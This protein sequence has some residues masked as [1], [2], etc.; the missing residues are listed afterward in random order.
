VIGESVVESRFEALHGTMSGPFVG[1]DKEL[2]LLLDRWELARLGEGQ[3]VLLAGEPGIGKSRIVLALRERLRLEDRISLRYHASP[4][5]ANS[6]WWPIVQQLERAAGF[7]RDDTNAAKLA[8]LEALLAQA[9]GDVADVIPFFADLLSL[10]T[11]GGYALP[12]LVPQEKKARTCRALLAQLEGL[13]AQKPVLIV[14]EDAHWL[15]PTTIEL[16]ELIVQ[17]LERLPVL[18]V[19]TF[20]PE[21]KPPWTGHPHVTALTLNR[22]GRVA[23]EAIMER[24]SGSRRLPEGLPAEILARA[25]GVP[26]FVEELT[27]TILESGILGETADAYPLD[28]SLLRQAIPA[29]LQDSLMARLDRLAPVKEVAQIGAVI[30]R[31]FSRELLV[32]V[33]GMQEDQLGDAMDRLADAGLIFARGMPPEITYIFKHSLVQEAARESLL[34]SRRH[35]LN[36]KVAEVLESRFPSL[37]EAEPERLAHHL[38]EAGLADRAATWWLKAAEQAWRRVA[39]REA[40][41]HLQRGI[42]ILTTLP[43]TRERQ[44][45]E[46]RL[47]NMLALIHLTAWGPSVGAE[48]ALARARLLCTEDETAEEKFAAVFNQWLLNHQRLN[49]PTALRLVDEL[50]DSLRPDTPETLVLQAHH[51]AWSAHWMYGQPEIGYRHAEVG[52]ELYKREAH[53]ALAPHFSGHDAGVCCRY[54]LGIVNQLLGYP[55]RASDRLA[56]SLALAASLRHPQS[57]II[58]LSFAVSSM[59]IA[60]SDPANVRELAAVGAELSREQGVRTYAAMFDLMVAW[61]DMNLGDNEDPRPRI[62]DALAAME[63]AGFLLRRSFFLGVQAELYLATGVHAD[64]LAAV[65]AALTFVSRHGEHFY[66]PELQRLKGEL[67]LCSSQNRREEAEAAFLCATET[68]RTANAR[69]LGLR[70]ATSLARFWAEAGERRRAHDLLAPAYGWFTEGFETPDLKNAKALL[71][72]LN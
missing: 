37:A 51:A 8:K 52:L 72:Q 53:H 21:F 68:A 11:E 22:L 7:A 35:Q 32:A 17:R 28:R 63:A 27:K 29:T 36:G 6:A 33:T 9:V 31:E 38:T 5:H 3:V 16:F 67:L 56:D 59:Y 46:A 62:S 69:W 64:G 13:A 20:R 45:L 71:E 4:Y 54:T 40:V 12:P 66:E 44:Y 25:D 47:Q 41:A 19:V 1:R 70:G 58:A 50:I 42:E 57:Q 34:K 24:L 65:E 49:V 2:A 18:L 61:A 30:G 10:P 14:L 26:L 48:T 15:D 39:R 23:A 55:D 43:G 60:R